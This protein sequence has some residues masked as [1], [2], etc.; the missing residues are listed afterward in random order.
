MTNHRPSISA[1]SHSQGPTVKIPSHIWNAYEPQLPAPKSP[2]SD[3]TTEFEHQP[4]NAEKRKEDTTK[5]LRRSRKQKHTS[6]HSNEST[7]LSDEVPAKS[8]P[9]RSKKCKTKLWKFEY[10][11]PDISL[12]GPC[13]KSTCSTC[14]IWHRHLVLGP[15]ALDD[16][17]G[18]DG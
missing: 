7:A 6:Q 12:K 11:K 8:L 9:T 10:D 5:P 18:D 2:N 14:R 16:E 4:K 3:Q 17:E 15:L 1:S 13:L